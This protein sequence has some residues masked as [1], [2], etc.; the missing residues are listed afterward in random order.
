MAF[1]LVIAVTLAT[2]LAACGSAPSKAVQRTDTGAQ[3]ASVAVYP[4]GIQPFHNAVIARKAG[5][6]PS[7]AIHNCCFIGKN[8]HFVLKKPSGT[9]VATFRFFVPV[10]KPLEDGQTVTVSIQSATASASASQG[11]WM[12]VSVSLP[13]SAVGR[14]TVAAD[15]VSAKSFVPTRLGMS[16][17]NR[18]LSVVLQ[19][20]DYR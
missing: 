10:A 6:Y 17:D 14:T 4:P 18:E 15:V 5:L 16:R 11:K 2:L 9:S 12:T 1:K 3:I 8:A 20:V 13:P 19:R 7:F